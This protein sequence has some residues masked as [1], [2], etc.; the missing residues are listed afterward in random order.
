MT[1]LTKNTSYVSSLVDFFND[2]KPFHSK[3]TD[4]IEEYHF[5]DDMAVRLSEKTNTQVKI[6]AAWHYQYNSDGDKSRKASFRIKGINSAQS[7]AY[8][9]HVYTVGTHEN[10]DFVGV[11]FVYSKSV[12]ARSAPA[13]VKCLDTSVYYQEG[14]DYF[15]S[16]GGMQ[17]VIKQTRDASSRFKPLWVEKRDENLISTTQTY[18][19]RVANDITK[20]TSSISI[21]KGHLQSLLSIQNIP[22]EA[23]LELGRLIT[24]VSISSS[25]FDDLAAS[26]AIDGLQFDAALT[27]FDLVQFVDARKNEISAK[28]KSAFVA[29]V[30]L[31]D[32]VILPRDYEAA[33][34]PLKA[35]GIAPPP[36]APGGWIG[37]TKTTNCVTD[38]LSG[39]TPPLYFRTFTDSQFIESGKSYYPPV[40]TPYLAISNI[41]ITEAAPA[42]GSWSIVAY[43]SEYPVYTVF[44]NVTGYIGSFT[45]VRGG[46]YFQSADISFFVQYLGQAQ[47]GETCFIKNTNRLV[48]GP[49]APLETWD[50]IK[51][52]P[53][54]YS[55][56]GLVSKR[57]G[58]I[59]NLQNVSGKVSIN[60]ANSSWLRSGTIVLTCRADKTTFDLAC[61][62][63]PTY[64]GVARVNQTFNDGK[65]GFT[66]RSGSAQPFAAGDKFFI[67]IKNDLAFVQ[68]HDIFYGY[69]LDS[70]DNSESVYQREFK[71]V[72]K[73]DAAGFGVEAIE[74]VSEAGVSSPK[75]GFLYDTRFTDYDVKKMSIS[76]SENSI[77]NRAW[78]L[79]AVPNLR[80]PM[81]TLK[82]DLSTLSEAIDLQE[83]TLGIAPDPARNAAPL[84]SMLGDSNNTPDIRAYYAD[85]FR[86]EYSDNA[87]TS[88]GTFA[89]TVMV[90]GAYSNTVHGISFSLPEASKPFIAVLADDGYDEN[91][92][93][94]PIVQGGDII[95][96]TVIN[97]PPEV[98]GEVISIN[99]VNA[100]Q[101][102][103][104]GEGFFDAP[105]AT[106]SVTFTSDTQYTVS[107]K[108]TETQ[109][110]RVVAGLPISA[111]IN[112]PSLSIREGTSFKSDLVHFTIVPPP[113]G[114]GAGDTFTFNTFSK[115][116]SYLVHGSASGWMPE[117]TVGEAY[118]N[119]II[120]FEIQKS[121]AVLF[122]GA[123]SSGLVPA[124]SENM[125][126]LG[127]GS[128][129]LDRL[130]VDA[131][132]LTYTL[133]P[134]PEATPPGWIVSRAD[135]GI[136]GRIEMH[137][138][139][140]D[141]YITITA[142]VSTPDIR[143][144]QLQI[145][146]DDF[147][148]WNNK[149]A[150][151]VRA[152]ITAMTPLPNQR[153][154][155]DKLSAD[156]IGI[157]MTYELVHAARVP[158]TTSLALES[159]DTRRASLTTGFGQTPITLTSPETAHLR[160][161]VP[162]SIV[163]RDSSTS[164]A[165]SPNNGRFYDVF[166]I[167]TGEKIGVIAP[168]GSND[169]WH[170]TFTWDAAFFAKYLPLS[171]FTNF[172]AYGSSGS[173]EEMN[174]KISETL[175]VMIEPGA[176][177]TDYTLT[178]QLVIKIAEYI[179]ETI[180]SKEVDSISASIED[181]PFAGFLPGYGNVSYDDEGNMSMYDAGLPL[182]SHYHEARKLAGLD[183]M[184]PRQLGMTQEE[185]TDRLNLL[186]QLISNFLVNN[187]LADTSLRAFTANMDADTSR[188]VTTD[189]FG[190]PAKGLGIGITMGKPGL[191]VNKP[192]TEGTSVGV[193]DAFVVV[194]RD[195][196]PSAGT[197]FAIFNIKPNQMVAP[198][199]STFAAFSTP[200]VFSSVQPTSFVAEFNITAPSS[201][202]ST[203]KTPQI[204]VWASTWPAPVKATSVSKV[205]IGKYRVTIASATEVKFYVIP[206][207]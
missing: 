207:V 175:K 139:F 125:W 32:Q 87:F 127:S 88:A 12:S 59:T 67:Q 171:A 39:L 120:G 204:F 34:A 135:K 65:I 151:L 35:A 54:A 137:G 145:I 84:F 44:S 15:S 142:A 140:K 31:L 17:F 106:W 51:T 103:M 115:K 94:N 16:Y 163:P 173:N 148:M 38:V 112:T 42:G 19:R 66:I 55:R 48:F 24:A 178:D 114:F 86:V 174:I 3:L 69:D 166:A 144:L 167:G 97:K 157:N 147:E 68:G 123:G 189:K 37:D 206:G 128:I 113:A 133:F 40:T 23:Q 53:L 100:P 82:K 141:E 30:A 83:Q 108:Y 161:W 119:G 130:R 56:P 29:A 149:N 146:G 150:V 11:P 109:V 110:G 121:K 143:K 6:G 76:L 184:T 63:D 111:R 8:N 89:G 187:K 124:S 172:V 13:F 205:G 118:W 22:A 168:E 20:S 165:E 185:R 72:D 156:T 28:T 159:I 79:V 201:Y 181:G 102:I 33:L 41:K 85:E 155:I 95:M 2:T 80:R 131:P 92:V 138:L 153:F 200:L 27:G 91:G 195:I 10:L 170:T 101:M 49:S 46:E 190:Y 47:V 26:A 9:E 197:T 107:A 98:L 43:D 45:A 57:F 1:S 191:D 186:L 198:S 162:L 164:I 96:F 192:S 14:I 132:T 21:I 117:A 122:E 74:P 202:T 90:N 177:S 116:P 193:L 77:T 158:N 25:V 75:I 199:I 61:T 104:H 36:W 58:Y 5:F 160:N 70:Y 4:V 99:S 93:A 50:I 182:L 188:L 52:N 180:I 62:A 196:T 73:F 105:A 7:T 179:H 18:T 129:K 126:V 154:L 176:L 60:L 136:V 169:L 71:I 152:P 78:R 134:I 64:T 194:S 81:T 183:P 203:M